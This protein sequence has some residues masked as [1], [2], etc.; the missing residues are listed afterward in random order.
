[1]THVNEGPHNLDQVG[2]LESL[3]ETH[4]RLGSIDDAKDI[5]DMIYAINEHAYAQNTI[6][7]VPALMSRAAWQ[8]RAGFINDHRVT[9][10]RTIKIIEGDG[11]KNDMRLVDPLTQLGQSYFFP[12]LSGAQTYSGS[13][14]STGETYFKRALRIA[15]ADPDANWEMIA[16][17]SLALGNFYMIREN[18][19]QANRIYI[20][21]WADLSNGDAQLAYRRE[22]L[23]HY[24]VLR[25]N[26]IPEYVS[27]PKSE[28]PTGQEIPFLQGTITIKY[29][30]STHGRATN[31]KIVEAHPREFVDMQGLIYRELRRRVFRPQYIDAKAINTD[32]EIMVH[33]F[34]YRQ[35]D[36][37]A[38]LAAAT[39]PEES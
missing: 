28:A 4:L 22:H 27:P 13:L 11:G 37:D 34:F 35:A 14:V 29:D 10:R 7:M 12:D 6:A 32:N 25:S 26:A 38:L 30:V 31:L 16:T 3:S 9:L 15:S 1:V 24:A 2:I 20:A 36:L 21:T 18:L 39:E 33:R 23:E 17:T 19:Q 8:R 5:Q